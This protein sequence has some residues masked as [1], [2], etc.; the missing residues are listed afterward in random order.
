[1]SRAVRAQLGLSCAGDCALRL[2]YVFT[3]AC[4]VLS[5]RRTVAGHCYACNP[6]NRKH[7]VCE[8]AHR[9][10]TRRTA[11]VAA[12]VTARPTAPSPNTHIRA[13]PHTHTQ[14]PAHRTAMMRAA[15]ARL[16]ASMT[17][18]PTAPD[19]N[20]HE[21]HKATTTQRTAMMRAA[22][23]RLA[24]SMTARPTAPSPN[25]AT[26]VPGCT[27]AVLN[28]APHP[29]ETPQPRRHTWACVFAK[30][31]VRVCRLFECVCAG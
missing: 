17:A 3:P 28:T 21:T 31:C 10:D 22:P 2:L 7:S 20:T 11:R 1:M 15:P 16:A 18:R 9:D 8:Y 5:S 12:S 27:L 30:V 29:V 13:P 6:P 26:L 14:F 19:P 24:A 23:A 25:T 4:Q